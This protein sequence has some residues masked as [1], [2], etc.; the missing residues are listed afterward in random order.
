M[1]ALAPS[2]ICLAKLESADSIQIKQAA[3]HRAKGKCGW[4]IANTLTKAGKVTFRPKEVTAQCPMVLAGYIWLHEVDKQAQSILGSGVKRIHHAGTYSCRRQ[5]GNGSG[6][7][8]EHAFANAWDITGF[9]LD[10]GRVISIYKDWQGG[11]SKQAKARRK[12][13]HKARD[14]ACR[15]FRVVLSPDFNAAH[16]DHFHFD[17]GPSLSCR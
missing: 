17:Q 4:K 13:L 9:E 1:I 11:R 10:D 16:K 6:A 15:V 3:P 2:R 7:W 5:R 12:F 14:K 8:S